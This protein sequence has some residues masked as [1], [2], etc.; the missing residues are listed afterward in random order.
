MIM[1]KYILALFV[2]LTAVIASAH[3]PEISTTMLS[4]QADGTWILQLSTSMTAFEHEVHTQFGKDSYKTPEEFKE[5]V[6][7]HVIA[8]FAIVIDGAENVT[9]ENGFVKLGHETSVVFQVRGLPEL[10]S[11]M[12]V[13]NN[14]FNNIHDSQS[15]L[16][17]LKKGFARKQFVLNDK[18]HHTVHLTVSNKSFVSEL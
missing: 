1:T 12:S 16:I 4:E 14:S 15:A 2:A 18:N 8:N 11:K 3:Q 7:R 10:I 13:R 17:I 9:L 6:L 5:L